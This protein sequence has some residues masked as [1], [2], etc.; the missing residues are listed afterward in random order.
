KR[1]GKAHENRKSIEC[2]GRESRRVPRWLLL[3]QQPPVGRR[4]ARRWRW[5][6]GWRRW[7]GWGTR[8]TGRRR[9]V[10]DAGKRRIAAVRCVAGRTARGVHQL[11]GRRLGTGRRHTGRRV[12]GWRQ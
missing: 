6:N 5:S 8:G 1:V 4:F 10:G 12:T 9:R 7:N 3:E 2:V 11:G